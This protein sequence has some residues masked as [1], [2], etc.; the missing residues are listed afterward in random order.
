MIETETEIAC[1]CC[2]FESH[3]H[4]DMRICASYSS[5]VCPQIK[6]GDGVKGWSDKRVE[7]KKKTEWSQ[8]RRTWGG[9]AAAN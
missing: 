3:H 1:C 6:I 8:G 5:G 2:C 9:D 4:H 7:N